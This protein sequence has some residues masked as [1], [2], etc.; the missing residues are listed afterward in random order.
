MNKIINCSYWLK[1]NIIKSLQDWLESEMLKNYHF[2]LNCL[3]WVNFNAETIYD[4]K[5]FDVM[6]NVMVL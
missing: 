3:F 6:P 1:D 4:K 2:N 5:L